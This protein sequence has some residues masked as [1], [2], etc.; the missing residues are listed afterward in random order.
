MATN[1]FIIDIVEKLKEDNLEYM[2]VYIQKGKEGNHHAN[3]YY[4]INSFETAE[5]IGVC[6]DEVYNELDKTL[7]PN[8][9]DPD[10]DDEFKEGTD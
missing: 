8:K 2:V 10:S 3:A 1:D 7:Q 6:V 4:D 9:K 5:M